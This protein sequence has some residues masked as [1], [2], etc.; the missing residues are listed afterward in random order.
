MP[1]DLEEVFT[2][3]HDT[4]TQLFEDEQRV[5]ALQKALLQKEQLAKK[6]REREEKKLAKEAEENLKR[7]RAS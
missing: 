7:V 6:K 5:Q 2:Q 3:T 1:V 4:C